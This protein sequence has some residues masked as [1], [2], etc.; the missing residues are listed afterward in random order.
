MSP[1]L[2]S[3]NPSGELWF[4]STD[5]CQS[6]PSPARNPSSR[7]GVAPVGD[8]LQPVCPG[9]L[10][11]TNPVAGML[12]FVDVGPYLGL[13]GFIMNRRFT[14]GGA[15][16]VQLP[17]QAGRDGDRPGRQL[18]KD[19]ADFLDVFVIANDVF[20]A[21]QVAEGQFSG[22]AFGLGASVKGAILGP[23]LFG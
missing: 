6:F 12:K 1:P 21:Q 19:A 4:Q 9:L 7:A 22:F 23:H 3:E 17:N 14:A 20:V 5:C 10:E 15:A 8:L 2:E 16:G 18:N 11:K 13:P